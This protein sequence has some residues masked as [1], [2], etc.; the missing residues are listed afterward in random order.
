MQRCQTL[1]ARLVPTIVELDAGAEV[2]PFRS[3]DG[4][5]N[6]SDTH[7]AQVF[8]RLVREETLNRV[9]YDG[10]IGN[11]TDFIDFFHN[12]ENEIFF[13]R[14]GGQEA[15]FFWLNRFRHRSYFI[16]YCFYREFWGRQALAISRATLDY[17]FS[18]TDVHG[19]HRI[20]TL[21]GLTPASNK[22]AVKFMLRNNM[23]I[24]GRVPGFLFDRHLG[25]RVDGILSYCQRQDDSSMRLPSLLLLL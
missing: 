22:L 13:G 24:V 1:P 2:V 9:F 17:L 10:S 18:R 11:T 8:R 12:Q 15:G 19:E 20:E 21:L 16:T 6:L 25:R 23:T 4:T 7:L 14:A 3:E 5:P